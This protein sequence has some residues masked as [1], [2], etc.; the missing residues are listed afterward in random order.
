MRVLSRAGILHLSLPKVK[1]V[2]AQIEMVLQSKPTFAYRNW[3][4]TLGRQP[5]FKTRRSRE[6]SWA[7]EDKDDQWPVK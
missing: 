7:E 2:P 1:W 5:D 3:H 4:G 6:F